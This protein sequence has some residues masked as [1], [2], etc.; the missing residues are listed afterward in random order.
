MIARADVHVFDEAHD[1]AGAAEMRQQVEQR[2][3]VDAALDDGVDLDR[4]E[5][6]AARVLDAV[7]HF[8][9]AAEAAAHLREH[10]GIERIEAH[11]DAIQAGRLELGGVLRQQH[12][13]GGERDVLD[14]RQ[15]T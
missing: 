14:A 8:V 15:L 4:R 2:V 7:E 12:A 6:R 5:A 13:V 11:G 9:D 3:I 1:D 10:L